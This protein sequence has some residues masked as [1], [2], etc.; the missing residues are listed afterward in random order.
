MA[1]SAQLVYVKTAVSSKAKGLIN[2]LC[3]RPPQYAPATCK[4]TFD[5]LTLKVVTESRV[6]GATSVPIL[7]FLGLSVLDLDPMHATGRRQNAHNRLMPPT[8]GVGA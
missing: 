3:E 1:A 6:M 7:V 5:L 2:K 8:L 4:L